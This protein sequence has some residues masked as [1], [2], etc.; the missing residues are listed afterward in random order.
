MKVKTS[1]PLEE[2][3]SAGHLACQ[4]CGAT[5]SMRYAL[6]GLG[7]ETVLVIPACCWT[8]LA[9]PVPM[10]SLDVNV[11]HSP[12]ACA[13]AVACGVKH[14]LVSR[15]DEGTCVVAWAGDG[16][17]FDIGLQALSGAADRDED[18]LYVCYD[19]E[20]YMNTGIQRSGGTPRGAWTMTT[21]GPNG[22]ERPKKDLDAVIAA[23]RPRYQATATPAYAEDMVR[24]FRKARSVKGFRF[25]R[26]LAPC[27]PGWKYESGDTVA[28][29]RLAVQTG[30]FPLWESEEGRFRLNLSP[31]K[32]KPVGE[33]LRRQARFRRLTAEDE[34]AIQAQVD[35]AWEDFAKRA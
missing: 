1:V 11:V 26:I 16:G 12:F 21:P 7:K 18:I 8:I 2:G 22:A 17:T 6:K 9:G 33:F 15:G 27:P 23:H 25:I 31:S 32:R 19:N 24:K 3:L 30:M 14:G 34:A 29:S 5:L 20:A 28:L 4:G 10:T 13:A 35:A